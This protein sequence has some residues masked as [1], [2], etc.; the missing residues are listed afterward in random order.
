MPGQLGSLLVDA[1][2]PPVHVHH[3]IDHLGGWPGQ[4]I[5]AESATLGVGHAGRDIDQFVGVVCAGS[6]IA[7]QLSVFYVKY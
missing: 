7:G 5:Q 4:D 1:A 3:V 2:G 6:D